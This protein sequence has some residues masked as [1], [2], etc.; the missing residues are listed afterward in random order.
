MIFSPVL[1]GAKRIQPAHSETAEYP[2]KELYSMNKAK[3][4]VAL[5]SL[6]SLLVAGG[7][8]FNWR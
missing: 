3:I 6:V 7:A 4:M 8:Y 5:T 2:V 1:Y